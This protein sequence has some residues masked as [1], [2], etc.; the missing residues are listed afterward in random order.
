MFLGLQWGYSQ[1]VT[2]CVEPGKKSKQIPK[3]ARESRKRGETGTREQ[4][5]FMIN[6]EAFLKRKTYKFDK[7][8]SIYH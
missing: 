1:A 6:V 7:H 2:G 5:T 4:R 8:K 3:K